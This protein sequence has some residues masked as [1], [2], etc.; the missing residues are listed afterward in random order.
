MP[1]TRPPAIL[2]GGDTNALSI[3]RSL[4]A[5]GVRVYTIGVAPF[6]ERSKWVT[7]LPVPR[8][9]RNGRRP[10]DIWAEW[11]LGPEAEHL[12]GSVVMATSDVGITAIAHHR[13]ALLGRYRL[14]VSDVDAQLAMLDKL[15][16]YEAARAGG[17]P[18]P[19]F[20]RVD[21]AEDL[22]KW[23]DELV[24]P[25]IVKPLLS[26]EYK[27]KFPGVTKFRLVH[28]WE[29]LQHGYRELADAGLAV[30]LVEKIPGGDELLCSYTT[31][32]DETGT[33]TFDYTKRM[34]RRNPPNEGL[35]CYHVT[36]DVPEVK[37]LSLQL[38]KHTG[39]RGLAVIEF[40][41]DLRDGRLK[42]IECNAR[43][44]AALPLTVASGLDLPL[45]VY[46]RILG[47]R[48]ELPHTYP[49]GKRLLYP[50]DDFRSFLALRRAGKLTFGQ[51]VRSLMHP[52]TFP[53]WSP[54]DPMPAFAR[55]FQ[56][57]RSGLR[58]FVTG[59]LGR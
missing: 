42:L 1:M 21:S 48:H 56:R 13:P 47:E 32:I 34:V 22:Q 26:H 16:T 52:Q 18:T 43:F 19:L 7:P 29:E 24:Y 35:G 4:G 54:R 44:S 3:A 55:G 31:Y 49:Y 10:E 38:I 57:A 14:D 2:L 50:I 41:R 33:P 59:R 6:V 46:L 23:R 45:H 17:V 53:V 11:L 27:E 51:W 9:G 40:V 37:E 25:L 39:L 28:D 5:A 15:A 12:A 30:M 58:K 36:D 20:W 8:Q